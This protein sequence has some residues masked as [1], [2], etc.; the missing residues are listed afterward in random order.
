MWRHNPTG[1][2]V[3]DGSLLGL[4]SATQSTAGAVNWST[5]TGPLHTACT[6]HELAAELQASEC[7]KSEWSKKQGV[8]TASLVIPEPRNYNRISVI[9]LLEQSE[10]IHI[11]WE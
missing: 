6:S 8:L 11:Q 10:S 1:L 2:E 5:D 3:Q 4:T 9:L 7:P